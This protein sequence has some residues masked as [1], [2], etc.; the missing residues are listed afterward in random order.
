MRKV[1]KKD[2][3]PNKPSVGQIKRML[4]GTQ[5][6]Y[7]NKYKDQFFMIDLFP[8]NTHRFTVEYSEVVD[9]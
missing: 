1:A 2:G 8:D 6:T 5:E 7:F 3:L 4:K 9:F